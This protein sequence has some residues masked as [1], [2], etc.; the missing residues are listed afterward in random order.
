M[1]CRPS[2]PASPL[3]RCSQRDRSLGAGG[4]DRA[5]EPAEH[6]LRRHGLRWM[7]SL[8]SWSVP[9]LL[10]LSAWLFVT[11]ALQYPFMD[12]VTKPGEGPMTFLQAMNI[13]VG[14]QIAGSFTISD[15]SRY[16]RNHRSV[17]L[18]I[19]LAISPVSAF[20]MALGA[21]SRLASGNWNPVLAVESL[22]LGIPA[23]LLHHLRDVDDERQEP[24]LG[25]TRADEPIPNQPRWRMTLVLG[26]VGTVLGCFLRHALLHA[27]AGGAGDRLRAA[28]RHRPRRLLRG[29]AAAAARRRGVSCEGGTLHAGYQPGGAGGNR[30][31]GRCRPAGGA[32][33]APAGL[34][35]CSRRALP[36]SSGMRVIYPQQFQSARRARGGRIRPAVGYLSSSCSRAV[37]VLNRLSGSMA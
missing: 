33:D 21:L 35:P 28:P 26:L 29:P 9:G 1:R 14:A 5:D 36:T 16:A 20:M 37:P 34:S 11:I 3:I 24:L 4:D 6:L 12:L 15:L 22:G 31:R 13:T 30:D 7:Q 17:W 19:L 18:G 25:G 27:V 2:S 23:M 10:L 8:A 32:G